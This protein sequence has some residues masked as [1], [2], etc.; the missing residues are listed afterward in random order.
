MKR[1]MMIAA[2]VSCM[3]MQVFSQDSPVQV[4]VFRNDLSLTTMP[5]LV[6]GKVLVQDFKDGFYRFYT[7]DIQSGTPAEV[8]SHSKYLY[9]VAFSGTYVA[10]IEC[11]VKITYGPP[12]P[13]STAIA[14]TSVQYHVKAMNVADRTEHTLSTDTLF[15]EYIAAHGDKVVWTDYRHM[16]PGDTT[17]EIYMYDFSRMEESRVTEV[18][19]YKAWPHIYN[20]RI[21]WQDY[22][23]AGTTNNADI[24]LRDLD[25]GVETGICTEGSYQSQPHIFE[26]KVVWQD[27]RNASTEE[28]NADIFFKDLGTNEIKEVCTVSGYQG[29]PKVYG[30]YIVWQDYRNAQ[31]DSSNAD[32]YM[33]DLSGNT[34]Y[35]VTK[36]SGYQGEPVLWESNIVWQD[37]SDMFLY[38]GVIDAVSSISG[39]SRLLPLPS[40]ISEKPECFYDL[41]GRRIPRKSIHNRII[42][43]RNPT[44]S[45]ER[46]GDIR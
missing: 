15:K 38:K 26:D 13:G 33:Y 41:S 14:D 40:A 4:S 32:I 10:W 35:H 1:V 21:V 37:Y 46:F 45:I 31:Q 39:G 17:V 34:E 43:K 9:P 19:G 28:N 8:R 27:Y 30:N 22:R 44:G 11:Q 16:S 36:Q 24:F 3:S 6:D 42:L 20:N 7:F 25:S 12:S 2:I 5:K 29:T 23:H 18:Q